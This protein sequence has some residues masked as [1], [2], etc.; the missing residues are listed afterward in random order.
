MRLIAT[1][2]NE[3]AVIENLAKELR[4]RGF[5][6]DTT[7][8]EDGFGCTVWS[9]ADLAEFGVTRNWSSEE[10]ILF[11]EYAGHKIG[12]ATDESR[13]RIKVLLDNYIC[14]RTNKNYAYVDDNYKE[15][16]KTKFYLNVLGGDWV[17]RVYY[18][19][20]A[21]AGGQLVYDLLSNYDIAAAGKECATE[22]EFWTYT[23]AYARQTLIDIDTIDFEYA[24]KEFVEN[25]CDLVDQSTETMELLK[26]WAKESLIRLGSVE[27]HNTLS[28]E[29][30]IGKGT[31][32]Q[33]DVGQPWVHYEY[34]NDGEKDYYRDVFV[35]G[36]CAYMD[37][38][39]C[40][41]RGYDLKKRTVTLYSENGESNAENWDGIFTIPYEQ[42]V[43]DFGMCWTG[44]NDN[45]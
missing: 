9:V 1:M 13:E 28:N 18:N 21:S 37:G 11:M 26:K 45:G 43:A 41:I 4:N 10:K 16:D 14:D 8:Y 23:Y 34:G 5:N 6:V 17:R 2:K 24:A 27:L 22:D 19:P 36:H 35:D 15:F 30:C 40:K 39:Y 7:C 32:A 29:E 42:Y 44:G 3:N 20:D 25:P 12:G 33:I 31:C 38:E